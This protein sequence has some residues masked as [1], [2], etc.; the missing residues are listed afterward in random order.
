MVKALNIQLE[1][2]FNLE[3]SIKYDYPYAL[4]GL[5]LYD[6]LPI[7]DSTDTDLEIVSEHLPVES[8]EGNVYDETIVRSMRA[9]ILSAK[10]NYLLAFT[11][12]HAK[13]IFD[14]VYQYA[15]EQNKGKT[16]PPLCL[17]TEVDIKITKE[18]QH[19]NIASSSYI[20]EAPLITRIQPRTMNGQPF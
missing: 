7:Q 17:Y 19:P 13:K 18:K 20:G 4:F 3:A 1:T 10:K 5:G 16:N 15:A 11:E 14:Y 2:D 6:Q 12:D 9:N 8:F